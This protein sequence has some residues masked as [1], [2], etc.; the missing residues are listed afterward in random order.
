MSQ[1]ARRTVL[2]VGMF[3]FLGFA[4]MYGFGAFCWGHE[5]YEVKAPNAFSGSRWGVSFGPKQVHLRKNDTLV[6]RYDAEIHNGHLFIHVFKPFKPFGSEQGHSHYVRTSGKGEFL[7][8]IRE[9]CYYVI[10]IDTSARCDLSYEL[11]WSRR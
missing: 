8:P 4:A 5:S 10:S 9:T 6:V 11:S 1:F 3:A 7:V 2:V